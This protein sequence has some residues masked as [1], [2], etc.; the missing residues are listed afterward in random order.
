[1]SDVTI[2]VDTMVSVIELLLDPIDPHFHRP[3]SQPPSAHPSPSVEKEE[4]QFAVKPNDEI[5]QGEE[6]SEHARRRTI[7]ERMAKLGGIRFGAPPPVPGRR[8]PPSEAPTVAVRAEV[9]AED[10]KQEDESVVREEEDEHARRTR[11]AAKLA[12]MGGMRFGMYPGMPPPVTQQDVALSGDE[13]LVDQEPPVPPA[14]MTEPTGPSFTGDQD[15]EGTQ[16]DVNESEMEE[17]DSDQV[18]TEEPA[19]PPVP[20]RSGRQASGSTVTQ[21]DEAPPPPP[22]RPLSRPPVPH[23]R[24]PVPILPPPILRAKSPPGSGHPASPRQPPQHI[25]PPAPPSSSDFV[26]VDVEAPPP[27]P[28]R[29]PRLPPS[30]AIPEHPQL[31]SRE[32]QWELPSIPSSALDFGTE[33]PINEGD[34]SLAA[35]ATWS[36]DSTTYPAA[37]PPPPPAKPSQTPISKLQLST[38]EL[39]AIWGKVGVFLHEASLA[40]HEKSKRSLI[41]DGSYAGFVHAVFREVP[42]ARTPEQDLYGYLVYAQTGASVQ[43][44]ASD[45]MPGDV[46]VLHD[47]KL[48]GHKGLGTYHQH[49]GGEGEVCVGVVNEVE[50]K[51]S[52]IRVLQAN[53][54]VGHQVHSSCVRL[55]YIT[56]IVKQTVESVSYRLDDLKSGTIKVSCEGVQSNE[57]VANTVPSRYSEYWKL[58]VSSAGRSDQFLTLVHYI[59]SH[60]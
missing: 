37:P 23:G 52:K 35:S 13:E 36:E 24:P 41:G 55:F 40:L 57:F 7:A 45:I 5:A 51:K 47:A 54:H 19:P 50:T 46:I 17:V 39:M 25:Y 32:S 21:D 3:L 58:E 11:I 4:P 30:R 31:E 12:G 9:G 29:P 6:D 59:R 42:Q 27:P 43:R 28:D 14:R 8:A 49:V 48:K 18:D 26:I 16:V 1:V 33:T 20:S 38:D 22:R 10:T 53:Q 44:R 56:D 34:V 60:G 2:N 15:D